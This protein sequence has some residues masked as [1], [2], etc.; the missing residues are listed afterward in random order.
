VDELLAK[1]LG[2]PLGF[3][4]PNVITLD[5]A[6]GTGTYLLGVIDHALGKVEK[7]QGPGAVS[8][9][10]STL[11]KNLYGFEFMVGPYS[12][13][14]LRVSQALK[15]RGAII[16]KEGTK[17]YLTDTL[18]SPNAEPAN[19]PMYLRVISDQHDKAIQVKKNVPVIVCLGNPPY[20]RHEAA[21]D[22]N[23][24]TTGGWVRWGDVVT[25]KIFS[26]ST[27]TF[28]VGQYGKFL[29]IRSRKDRA[30]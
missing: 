16:P 8:G 4:D 23:H 26:T 21:T 13:S 7:H 11:A 12:V 30:S 17:I 18:E 25:L 6:V 28:G 15:Q 29:K 2:K 3:A 10:A 14:E 19:L 9:H 24:S 5:P 27:F 1:R 22:L 20:K